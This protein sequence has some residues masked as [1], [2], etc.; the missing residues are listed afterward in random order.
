[1][2]AVRRIGRG[3]DADAPPG[4]EVGLVRVRA[5]VGT[6]FEQ[7]LIGLTRELHLP[8]RPEDVP[9]GGLYVESNPPLG[10]IVRTSSAID[11][12]LVAPLSVRAGHGA[13]ELTY[14]IVRLPQDESLHAT[15]LD[16]E[17]QLIAALR[18]LSPSATIRLAGTALRDLGRA[19]W[20]ESAAEQRAPRR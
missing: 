19:T 6:G 1:M 15:V 9:Y 4:D 17:V 20:R 14:R 8:N 7:L 3:V 13:T 18:R 11:R 2:V 10:L 12:G 16:F 5:E